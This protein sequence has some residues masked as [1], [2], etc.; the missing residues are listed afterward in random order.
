[1]PEPLPTDNADIAV[2]SAAA[3][4]MAA[5]KRP[6]WRGL[7]SITMQPA[8]VQAD[9]VLTTA[10]RLTLVATIWAGLTIAWIPL[11]LI[12]LPHA[13]WYLAPLRL[14]CAVLF[15]LIGRTPDSV[16]RRQP[17][18]H[19]QSIGTVR[20]R[21]LMLFLLQLALVTIA[22]VII[23]TTEPQSHG[24]LAITQLTEGGEAI[25]ER[26]AYAYQP[27]LLAAAIGLFAL[28]FFD[29]LI[30]ALTI[31]LAQMLI[32]L[33][34]DRGFVTNG[35]ALNAID[36]GLVAL[37]LPIAA[38]GMLA[39]LS[40]ASSLVGAIALG[41]RDRLTQAL[42]R[43]AGDEIGT[44]E[45]R[46]ALRH[47]LHCTLAFADLDHFKGVNDGW[48][49]AAGDAVLATVAA[50][51]RA[52]LRAEDSVIRWGGEEFVLLLPMTDKAE[53]LSLLL[54]LCDQG[55]GLRPDGRRQTVS[56]GLASLREDAVAGWPQLVDLA[57][58]RMYAAKE[59]GR[60]CIIAEDSPPL[61]LRTTAAT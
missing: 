3:M 34:D 5:P 37:L 44:A 36:L 30:L 4:V 28:F 6:T 53:A 56:I 49:H 55:L 26:I 35:N 61:R 45:C 57:D 11:D 47:G 54:R 19:I 48:G 12:A 1:M 43:R 10:R 38:T 8:S 59:A 33:I 15:L 2:A 20:L 51:L 39:A 9:W 16:A 18:S 24:A 41:N 17:A 23:G 22:T 32:I 25:A 7:L 60:D 50:H 52:G 13:I 46:R 21:I 40:Q 27:L 58:R 29:G 31:C 42:T 14:A